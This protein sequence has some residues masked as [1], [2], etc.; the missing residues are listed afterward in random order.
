MPKVI[1]DCG[2]TKRIIVTEDVNR[3]VEML[4]WLIEHWALHKIIYSETDLLSTL[5]VKTPAPKV[6]EE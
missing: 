1:C 6:D 2:E 3:A 5:T 4:E